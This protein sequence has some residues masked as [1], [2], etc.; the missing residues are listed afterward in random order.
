MTVPCLLK[1]WNTP[2]GYRVTRTPIPAIDSLREG[3]PISFSVPDCTSARLPLLV[4]GDLLMEITCDAPVTVRLGKFGFTYD[5]A[6]GKAVFDG[7]E[8]QFTLQK[9]GALSLRALTDTCSCEFFLQNEIS[10][11]YGTSIPGKSLEIRSEGRFS[12]QG[13]S[14]AMK[15]IWNEDED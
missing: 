15:S 11:S 14:Y 1:L 9:K 13:T 10:A 7:G 12:I 5:P 3:A 8:K 4:Q 6:T 2:D